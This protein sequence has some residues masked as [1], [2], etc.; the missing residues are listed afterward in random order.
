[1]AV[2][3]TVAAVTVA[4]I[5]FSIRRHAVALS[6]LVVVVVVIVNK[7]RRGKYKICRRS[8]IFRSTLFCYFA[9]SIFIDGNGL[10]E[11]CMA[12]E[13]VLLQ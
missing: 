10:R 8:Y 6:L 7:S 11:E 3:V 9:Y 1:M 13:E 4:I 5:F 2:E 12:R